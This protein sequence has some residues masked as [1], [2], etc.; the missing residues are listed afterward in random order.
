MDIS[1]AKEIISILAEGIDPT[2]GE[3]LGA[4][5]VC[6]KGEVV[7]SFF[8]VIKVLDDRI[9]KRFPENAGKPWIKD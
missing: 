1:K 8:T 6:N 9:K 2:T 3:L 4:N 5:N 7:R